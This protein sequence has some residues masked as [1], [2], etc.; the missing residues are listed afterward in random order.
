M[1]SRVN[2]EVVNLTLLPAY[3]YWAPDLEPNSVHAFVKTYPSQGVDIQKFLKEVA[4]EEK[5]WATHKPFFNYR[6][7]QQFPPQRPE[8]NFLPTT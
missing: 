8:P 7:L 2:V 4:R 5:G 6:T 1:Y 3:V